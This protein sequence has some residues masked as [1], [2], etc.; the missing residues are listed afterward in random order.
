MT[1]VWI[2]TQGDWL[3]RRRHLVDRPIMRVNRKLGSM[4]RLLAALSRKMAQRV[5]EFSKE[6]V[7]CAIIRCVAIF[8]FTAVSSSGSWAKDNCA[9]APELPTQ[10]GDLHLV[11]KESF[12]D[13]KLGFGAGYERQDDTYESLSIYR[14][15]LGLSVTDSEL[16]RNQLR[17]AVNHVLRK[18][19]K[20]G[21]PNSLL[22]EQVFGAIV[23]IM[24]FPA[25]Y[26]DNSGFEYVGVGHNGKCLVKIRY[27]TNLS[28][29]SAA[30]LLLQSHL[31]QVRETSIVD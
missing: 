15:D 27:S 29:A 30:H 10:I 3:C 11:W 24:G 8:F 6:L 16:A 21:E 7:R 22:K 1:I 5:F 26:G 19:I 23:P 14:Y 4:F 20:L 12:E 9:S 17:Q 18:G 2:C 31:A 13:R 25:E 28:E